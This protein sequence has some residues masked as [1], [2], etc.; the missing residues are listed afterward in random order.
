MLDAIP[1]SKKVRNTSV[2]DVVRA[3]AEVYDIP[4]GNIWGRRQYEPV[5]EARK[6][7]Y[8]ICQSCLGLS[9]VKIGHRIG[10]RDHTTVIDGLRRIQA[11]HEKDFDTRKKVAGVYEVLFG[12]AKFFR[13][14]ET[15]E[16]KMHSTALSMQY[17]PRDVPGDEFGAKGEEW[18][19]RQMAPRR[20][21]KERTKPEDMSEMERQVLKLLEDQRPRTA[22]DLSVRMKTTVPVVP[23]AA[24]RLG[25]MKLIKFTVCPEG[26]TIYEA[27]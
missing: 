14:C 27:L 7:A 25:R 1:G 23:R 21:K 13:H 9:T 10:G 3:V 22:T 12:K 2:A 4:E 18:L 11:Q 26:V 24:M 8:L 17:K 16:D 15:K 5:A 6:V 19:A 20:T